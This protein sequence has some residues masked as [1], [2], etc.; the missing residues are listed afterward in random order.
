[1]SEQ[2]A[3]ADEVTYWPIK[4]PEELRAAIDVFETIKYTEV[5]YTPVF[6]IDSVTTKNAEAKIRAYA[7][8]LTVSG[9]PGGGLSLLQKAKDEALD[10]AARVVVNHARIA[11]PDAIEQL[12]PGFEEAAEAYIEAVSKLPDPLDSDNLVAAGVEAL[13]AYTDARAHARRLDTVE[14]WVISA[15]KVL[16]MLPQSV[17]TELRVLRPSSPGDL[18]ALEAAHLTFANPTLR[19]LD[20]V[21]TSRGVV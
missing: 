13:A 16:G 17:P 3:I 4:L 10:Q 5:G 21:V 6:D 14:N 11:I 7:Q 1:M 9:I 19:E 18:A 20:P 15:A 2:T 12:T 8:Q